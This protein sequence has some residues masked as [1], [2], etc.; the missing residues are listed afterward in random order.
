VIQVLYG[1][2]G[3]HLHAFR[4][5]RAAYSDPSFSLEETRDEYTMRVLAALSAGG[6][7]ITYEYDFGAS[8]VHEIALQKKVPREPGAGYPFCVKY[9]G[10]S[11]VE[12]PDCDSEEEQRPEPFD[13]EAVNHRLASLRE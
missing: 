1:W 5:R 13:L 3:D 7:K 11:P 4:V 6:G 10:D 9:S 8:W 2:D 12:Y